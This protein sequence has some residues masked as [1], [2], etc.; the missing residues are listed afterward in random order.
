[1]DIKT[2]L[3]NFM[4]VENEATAYAEAIVALAARGPETEALREE[5]ARDLTYLEKTTK[6]IQKALAAVPDPTV[7]KIMHARYVL[8]MTWLQ[9]EENLHISN[10]TAHRLHKQGLDWLEENL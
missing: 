5:Y 6:E 10:S 9:I 1:M 2:R 7:K 4:A 8:G 3:K